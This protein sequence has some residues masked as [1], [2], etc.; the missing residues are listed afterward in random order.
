MADFIQGNIL[1]EY[2]D[3]IRYRCYSKGW[4]T[5]GATDE[6]NGFAY[7]KSDYNVG[8]N[9][10]IEFKAYSRGNES[11]LL[12]ATMLGSYKSDDDLFIVAHYAQYYTA[13]L[14]YSPFYSSTSVIDRK[15]VV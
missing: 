15:S 7:F 14:F 3:K 6:D 1:T 10:I 4:A 12:L 8:K 9:T 11:G 2:T 5:P 13:R